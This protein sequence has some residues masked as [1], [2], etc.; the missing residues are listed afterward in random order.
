MILLK[1]EW[2]VIVVLVSMYYMNNRS[3]VVRLTTRVE[4]MNV[5]V[6]SAWHLIGDGCIEEIVWAIHCYSSFVLPDEQ[7]LFRM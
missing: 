3:F 5:V 2:C 4:N 7:K 6:V 1:P